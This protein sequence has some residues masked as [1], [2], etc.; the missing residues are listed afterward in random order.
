MSEK[1]IKIVLVVI[2]LTFVAM[3]FF[4]KATAKTEA[5]A[6]FSKTETVKVAEINAENP[7]FVDTV[8]LEQDIKDK[9]QS[10]FRAEIGVREL[11]GNNDGVRVEEYLATCNLKKGQ[12]WCAAYVNWC[13]MQIGVKGG[14]CYSPNWFP[15]EKIVKGTPDRCDVFGL[16]YK[17]KGRIAHVGFIDD[18][19]GGADFCITVEGNTNEGGSREGDGVYCK[20]RVKNQIYRVARWL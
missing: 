11:T 15:K 7:F 17:E 4:D 19:N 10:I 3:F 6:D 5:V 16:Y 9:L 8:I 12:P 13:Y 1:S 20:R 18:W 14:G 2:P